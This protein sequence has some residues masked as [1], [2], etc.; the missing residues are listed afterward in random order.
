MSRRVLPGLLLLFC[1]RLSCEAVVFNDNGAPDLTN[2]FEITHWKQG[3]MFTLTSDVVATSVKF[4]DLEALTTSWAN[5]ITYEI[6][7]NTASNQPGA[8]LFTGTGTSLTHVATGRNASP[9]PEFVITFGLPSISLAAGKYWLVLHNGALSNNLSQDIFWETAIT[10]RTDPTYEDVA[11]FLNSWDSHQLGN[12][13][14]QMA[15]QLSGTVRPKT[16]AFAF[17]SGK[18]AL[19]FTT[20][21]GQN[22]KVEFKNNMTDASWTTVSGASNVPG[23]GG[24]V[25]INDPDPNLPNVPRRFYRATVL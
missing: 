5:L 1:L 9:Y 24:V 6:R 22:Y 23:T 14:S 8:V 19:S 21:T 13:N 3:N 10:S 20:V 25:Q 18:P 7:A 11:P 16:T 2:G 12:N 4:W 15:F 17:V